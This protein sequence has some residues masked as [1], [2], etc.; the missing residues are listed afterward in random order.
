MIRVND[1]SETTVEDSETTKEG[2]KERT[3]KEKRSKRKNVKNR[4]KDKK[5]KSS[6]KKESEFSSMM[7][8][9]MGRFCIEN[10]S[11]SKFDLTSFESIKTISS[12]Y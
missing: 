5:T 10:G 12:D 4:S 9:K 6:C 7:K 11:K 8:K 1:S 2:E 3:K